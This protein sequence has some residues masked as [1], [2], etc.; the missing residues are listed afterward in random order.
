[1]NRDREELRLILTKPGMSNRAIARQVARSPNT[2]K[3]HRAVLTELGLN[4]EQIN[5]LDDHQIRALLTSPRG[6]EIGKRD[7]DMLYTHSQM[8]EP[9]VTGQ[10][11]WEEY[12]MV[13]PST[14]YGYSTFMEKY[15]TYKKSLGLAMRQ[16]Y[17]AGQFTFVDYA[18]RGIPYQPPGKPAQMSQVF[19]GVL[20]ASKYTFAYASESQKIPDWIDAHNQMYRFFGGVTEITVPDNLK[21]AVIKSGPDPE[22]NRSYQEMAA[23]YGTVIVPAR[24]RHPQDKALAEIGVQMVTRWIIAKLRKRRFTS[25]REINDAIAALL[26]ELN[27]KPLQK[28]PWSRRELFEQVERTH[29]LP[30][31]ATTF[32]PSSAWVAM[33]T[34]KAD[35]HVFVDKHYYSVPY[36]LVGL[37]VE[38]RI[39]HTTVEIFCAGKRVAGHVRSDV[40]GGTT[41]LPE[42]QPEAHRRYAEQTPEFFREWAVGVGEATQRFVEHQLTRTRNPLPG[43]R[44]CSSVKN[45]SRNFGTDRLEAAC[46]YAER[47]GS[48]TLTSLRSILR[49][50]LDSIQEPSLTVQGQLPLHPN[51]RGPGYY[52]QEG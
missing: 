15:R 49:R 37:K 41:T 2:I 43:I 50:N 11:V 23:H 28:L 47:I 51:V 35:Y 16:V 14:A 46:A 20:G 52:A 21:S 32:E 18:G 9:D 36:Q 4:W 13:E 3:T 39:T 30:L 34:V 10:L 40:V 5:Q 19:V 29:L 22:L 7:P 8:L 6:K 17:K 31:P 27:N 33:Q 1:M 25:I 12:A 44:V 42:H 45:L 48:L 24:V 38:A 26:T